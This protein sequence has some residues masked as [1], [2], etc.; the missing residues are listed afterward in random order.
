MLNIQELIKTTIL[1]N[2][3][4]TDPK[5]IEHQFRF[6]EFDP[7]LEVPVKV[8]DNPSYTVQGNIQV[9]LEDFPSR[10]TYLANTA[11]GKFYKVEHTCRITI[12][13][14]LISYK[15]DEI[16]NYKTTFIN[17]KSEIDRILGYKK[18]AIQGITNLE[19]GLQGWNDKMTIAVG[20]GTKVRKEPILWQ[21]EQ[22][23]TA[24]YYI[25]GV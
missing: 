17:M 2:W 11:N 18:F 8:P 7:K 9:L 15:A 21:S 10:K 23:V 16:G 25:Y 22:L 4:I 5:L 13:F 1:N 3:N 24:I 12:Y 19:M 6:D 20:R 14:K